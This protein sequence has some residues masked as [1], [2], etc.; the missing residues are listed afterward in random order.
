MSLFHFIFDL[1]ATITKKE[2]LPELASH[3]GCYEIMKKITEDTM[4]GKLSFEESFL[5]RIEM[6]K[7]IP[8]STVREIVDSIELNSEIVKFIKENS[9][10]CTVITGNLDVWICELMKKLGVENS[11][12][13][14]VATYNEEFIENVV[15]IVE[16]EKIIK[17]FEGQLVAVG[18]GSNDTQ[19]IKYADIGIGFGGVREIAPSILEVCNYAIYEEEKLCQ[20]LRRLL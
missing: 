11:Y 20:F 7:Q 1:D 13:S 2:I 12:Y 3:I 9:E 14:S 16:K 19:M 17:T 8:I 6:L 10:R 4:L 5:K 18:D 15:E